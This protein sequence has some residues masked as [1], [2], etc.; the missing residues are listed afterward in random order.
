MITIDGM[1]RLLSHLDV[2]PYNVPTPNMDKLANE[3]V[4]FA[5][6]HCCSPACLPSRVCLLFSLSP[7]VTG[8]RSNPDEWLGNHIFDN[9][10]NFVAY[11]NR[12]GYRTVNTGRLFH[13]P[14]NAKRFFSLFMNEGSVA[15]GY[16]DKKKRYM[17]DKVGR[18]DFGT[19]DRPL[20]KTSEWDQM[21]LLLDQMRADEASEQPGFY[22][23][24]TDWGQGA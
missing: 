23:L 10:E 6:A 15:P 1:T 11:L 18:Y 8:V 12:A 16:E 4:S 13:S 2:G 9:K 22:S 7:K 19:V 20:D 17:D 21:H 24:G 5:N 14:A 3:G